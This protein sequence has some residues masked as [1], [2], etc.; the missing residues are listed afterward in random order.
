MT[1]EISGSRDAGGSKWH[2]WDPHIH[3]PGTVFNDQYRGGDAWEQF[4]TRVETS[5]PRIRALGITDYYSLDVYEAVLKRRKD[6][7]LTEVD[8]I[9]PNVELRYAIGTGKGS[10]INFHLLVSPDDPDHVDRTRRF[11]RAL[12]FSAHGES[13][14]CDHADLVRLGRAHDRTLTDEQAAFAAGANQFKV[15]PEELRA[16]WKRSNWVQNNVLIA[17]AA[18]SND[19]TSGLQGDPSLSTLRKEIERSAHIIFSSQPKQREFWLGQGVVSIEKLIS[20]WNGT[21][22]CLHGSDAHGLNSVG[23][24]DQDRYCWIKGDLTFD[25]LRQI[26]LEPQARVFIG[27]VPPRGALPSQVITS[28]EVSSAPWILTPRISLNRGL[29][30][31][32]GA[33]GSGKTALAD[34]IAAGGCSLSP[35]LSERSFIRRAK[36]HLG[37]ASAN[38][39]W[40]DGDPT[41]NE[42]RHVEMED[43]FYSQRVQYLSQQFVD[44]LCSAEGITDE[45]LDEVERVIYQAHPA[46]DRM[47]TT[48]FRE[49]LDLHAARG[50]AL[51]RSHE[52]AL[53]EAAFELNIERDRKAGLPGL[54][55]QRS[56]KVNW[57]AKD[58][59]DRISLIGNGGEERAKRFD[60]ASTALES[61][62]F[63]IE[64][65]QRQRQA[66]LAL[67]DE[68]DD[69]RKT[70]APARLRQLQQAHSEALLP[71]DYWKAFRLD[72]SGDVDKILD[73]A[74]KAID[75]RILATSGRAA[76]GLEIDA[77]GPQA[78]ESLLEEGVTLV[79]NT[80]II[81][82]KEVS[83]LRGLIGIDN[84]N[85]KSFV[86]LSEK[87]SRDEAALA[88][89]DREINAAEKAD[90]RIK[91]LIQSRCDNYASVFD[92][93]IDEEC[94][95]SA[96]YSPLKARLE[97]EEGTL[98]KLSFDI[99]RVI[100]IAAWAQQGE[101]LLDLRKS[102]SFKGR[103]ALLAAARRVLQSA[104]ETGSSAEVAIAMTRFRESHERHLVEHAPVDRSDDIQ[105]FRDW[106]A[107]ISGWLY[108]T[109]H[110]S[111][112]YGVQYEG[113]NIEQLSPGTRGIVLLLLYLTID[114]DD[115]RPLIIDQPEENLDPKSIF[116]DLVAQF[117]RTKQRRQ[118]IIVTHNANLVVNT[119]ADQVIVASCGPHRPGMLPEITYLSGGLE[120]STIRRLVCEI[121]EGGEAAFRQRAL[122]LRIR[123]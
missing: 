13:Y 31:I 115:D 17:V 4:L 121:L 11:L 49:L 51:R 103:G 46:E 38:L 62:R 65:A 1:E 24:V 26:C 74:I 61:V 52:E 18:G 114:R 39:V 30:A 53:A 5:T 58:K 86:R 69:M 105:G 42:L 50:R 107:R 83:R 63:R 100:D 22:P 29:V 76:G 89:L 28:V 23:V 45:L 25:T 116:D 94:S 85:A 87:I 35:H 92:G 33:R 71:A 68:V 75:G 98:G 72:F 95:L 36:D 20:G 7:R 2:R 12:T 122:R 32:I 110:I 37:E 101:N 60:E 99:R 54:Q 104:W 123:V 102:G 70:K 112:S 43:V 78:K 10:P 59:R 3:A 79:E 119:D 40:E 19:G 84:E 47:G 81:L 111:V 106:A 9:F 117:R 34:I 113:V 77:A 97:A 73:G 27:L 82:T 91:E 56:E 80:L 55:R 93:I 48:S 67:K 57:I 41:S 88:K 8:L 66:L 96:L 14:R 15:N 118:I 109:T 6:G 120:N 16:E 90:D 44:S 64:Q 108:G 21:K